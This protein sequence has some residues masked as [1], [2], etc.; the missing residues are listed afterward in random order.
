MGDTIEDK[1]VQVRDIQ[2]TEWIKLG[3]PLGLQEH[4]ELNWEHIYPIL[5]RLKEIFGVESFMTLRDYILWLETK[6]G[7]KFILTNYGGSRAGQGGG[8]Y[9]QCHAFKAELILR[10]AKEMTV[11]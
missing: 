8:N 11:K 6:D 4:E 1:D 5:G 3:V 2:V 7:E 9:Y 10:Y